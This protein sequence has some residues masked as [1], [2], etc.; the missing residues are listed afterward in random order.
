MNDEK[1]NKTATIKSSSLDKTIIEKEKEKDKDKEKN[2][3]KNKNIKKDLNINK[4]ENKIIHR[5]SNDYSIILRNRI[6]KKIQKSSRYKRNIFKLL[7]DQ[8]RSDIEGIEK[9]IE[10]AKKMIVPYSVLKSKKIKNELLLNNKINQIINKDSIKEEDNKNKK[11][12][13]KLNVPKLKKLSSSFISNTSINSSSRNDIKS[14]TY[15]PFSQKK[16]NNIVNLKSRNKSRF[17]AMKAITDNNKNNGSINNNKNEDKFF[18]ERYLKKKTLPIIYKNGNIFEK[19]LSNFEKFNNNTFK[20]LNSRSF[21]LYNSRKTLI[22]VFPDE[23]NH[24][25]RKTFYITFDERWYSKNQYVYIKIDK[26]LIENNYIQAQIIHDQY[27]LINENIKIITTEYIV[28]KDLQTNFNM[29]NLYNQRKIN[30]NIEESIGLMIEISYLLLEKYEDSLPNF[31]SQ[32]MKRVKKDVSKF[33]DDEKK[34]FITNIALF[35][36]ATTF[37]DISYKSFFILIKKDQYY[38]IKKES[39]CKL[40]QYLDRLR[41]S[42]SKMVL[43]IKNLYKGNDKRE[44]KLITECV[45]KMI[46]IK[47][48]KDFDNRKKVDCHRKFGSFHSGIDPFKYKGGV[49]MK[50]P[51]EKEIIMRINRALGK[52]ND[53]EQGYYNIKKFDV[54]SKLVTNLMGYATKEFREFIISER[55]RRKFYESQNNNNDDEIDEDEDKKE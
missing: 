34:E 46:R 53:K 44:K 9:E 2:V 49:R 24:K 21:D 12:D 55:I 23:E 47:E 40:H 30:I 28:D 7:Y 27:A 33:V 35:N 1:I 17:N 8:I 13:S 19:K 32:V 3:N 11:N 16:N 15:N 14:K 25:R 42:M 39:F 48:H 22:K 5:D 50:M 36:E 51:E 38:K 45:E 6:N 29:S 10:I 41:L 52:K 37:L 43:D 4:S 20:K 26:L 54:G 18:N 31:I